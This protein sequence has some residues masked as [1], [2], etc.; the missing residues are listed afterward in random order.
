MMAMNTPHGGVFPFFFSLPV[1]KPRKHPMIRTIRHILT[2]LKTN[3]LVVYPI[4]RIINVSP[5]LI[6]QKA[7]SDVRLDE[8]A[9]KSR[10][11]SE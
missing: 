11:K 7:Y 8:F 10:V 3:R 5:F 6:L 4:V 2:V 9:R 1:T